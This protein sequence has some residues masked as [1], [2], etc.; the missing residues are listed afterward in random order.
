MLVRHVRLSADDWLN[1][2]FFAL[3]IKIDNAIHVAVI[4]HAK[5]WHSFGSC[6]A[7]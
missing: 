4:G 2:F 1:S 7:N 3:F 5:G 6:F